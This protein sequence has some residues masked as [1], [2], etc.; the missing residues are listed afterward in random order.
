MSK[1]TCL[2]VITETELR[3]WLDFPA[4][5][6]PT[7]KYVP[8]TR[9]HIIRLFRGK[10]PYNEDGTIRF[11]LVR[12][13]TGRVVARSSVHESAKFNQKLQQN[14]QLFGFTEFVNDY[15][16]F[17]TLLDYVTQTARDNGKTLI[18]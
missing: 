8:A 7:G 4:T 12:D 14:I 5:L 13:A 6:Y 10:T 11:V 17:A 9:Q 1:L 2:L 16:V 18:F 3:E 15:D